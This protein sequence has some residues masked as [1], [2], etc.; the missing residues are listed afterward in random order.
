[1]RPKTS[2]LK[3]NKDNRHRYDQQSLQVQTQQ[4]RQANWL[5]NKQQQNSPNTDGLLCEKAADGIDVRT[6]MLHQDII[7]KVLQQ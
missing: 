6:A 1:M 2:W 3:K 4:I 5:D 7:D